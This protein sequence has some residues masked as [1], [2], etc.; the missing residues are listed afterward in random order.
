MPFACLCVCHCVPAVSYQRN[1]CIL[2][3]GVVLRGGTHPD[4]APNRV[5]ERPKVTRQHSTAI[6]ALSHQV[7][8]RLVRLCALPVPDASAACLHVHELT[9]SRYK[10]LPRALK[11]DAW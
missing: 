10:I 5:L 8:L 9:W 11:Y 3:A 2:S 4:L 1:G 6:A 7:S